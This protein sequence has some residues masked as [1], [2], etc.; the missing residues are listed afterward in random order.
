MSL[1]EEFFHSVHVSPIKRSVE[2]RRFPPLSY[3]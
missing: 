2:R 3:S 1:V